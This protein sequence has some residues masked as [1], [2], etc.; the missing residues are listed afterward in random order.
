MTNV[1]LFD[2]LVS[3]QG[4]Q[5]AVPTYVIWGSLLLNA[6]ASLEIL[7]LLRTRLL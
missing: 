1:V 5:I 6:G 3:I 4:S 7:T 2:I